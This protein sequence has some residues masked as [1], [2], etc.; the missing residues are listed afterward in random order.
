MVTVVKHDLEFILKQIKIAER[1]AAG[2]D[3]D[4]L[5]A[6]AGGFD[7]NSPASPQ[8][9]L[10]PYG[11]RTVD[12]SY[13]NLL[14]GRSEWGAADYEFNYLTEQSY[15]QGTGTFPYASNNDYGSSGDVVDSHPRLISNLIVDQTLDNPAAIIAAL[16][17]AGVTGTAQ[18]TALQNIRSVYQTLKDLSPNSQS[19]ATVKANLDT[20]LEQHGIEMDGVTIL[21]PN[22]S[23]DIGDSAPYNS[24][25]TLFG[26]F[27][28]HGLDLV[29]KGG[30]GTIY[31]PLS[32]DDPLYNPASPQ[33][34]F[35]VLT[36]ASTG[37]AARNTTTPWVDQNQT[38]GSHASKQVFMRQYVEGPDGKPMDS[39]YLLGHPDGMATWADV[40]E[41]ARTV[42]GIEL[43]DT[44]VGNIPLIAADEYGNFIEGQNGYPQLVVGFGGDGIFGTEDDVLV[45][46]DPE[47]PVSP[48]AVGAFRTG[49]AFIDDIAHNAVPGTTYYVNGQPVVVQP[50]ED[51]ETDDEGNPILVGNEIDTDSLGNKVAYDDELLDAHYVTGD[52]RGNENIGLTAIH[53]VFHGEHNRMVD[54]TKRVALEAAEDGD[55]TF[56]NEWLL[57]KVTEVPEDLEDLVWDGARL[58]QA[59]RFVTEMEYQHLVFEEFARKMQPDVDAFLFEPDPDI[60]PA[61]FAEFANVVYRFGHSMLNENVERQYA[62]GERGD[63]KLFEA[64]LNPVGYDNNGALTH[65]QAAGAIIRGMSGQLGNEIDEFVTNTLR[66]QL[67]GIPLDLASINIARGRDT[68]MPT[69]N[70]ARAQFQAMAGGDTQLKPYDNWIDFAVN[71]KNPASI[72]NFIAAYGTH[73]L[74]EAETTIDGKRA[75]A[76]AIVFGTDEQ[77]WDPIISSYRTIAAPSAEDRAAFLGASGDYASNLGGLNSVDLWVGGLAEKK[78]DFG[79]MLGS[80]FS[81]IFEMQ[82]ERLQ[83]ADRFYYLSRVQGLNLISELEGNS[84]AKMIQRN[85][86]IGD[87][88]TAIPGDIF[89][90]PDR[91]LY[92][93]HDKQMAMTGLDDPQHE[94]IFWEA[95]LGKMVQRGVDAQGRNYLRYDGVEHVVIQGTDD[96]DHII[97]GE[98]DD[99]VWG[100]DGNDR[101]EAGYGVDHI[102]GGKGDDI[103]TN[104]GTDIGQMDFL[105][106]E[107]GNDVIHGGSGLALI[108]GNQGNDFLIAGPDGKQVWGGIGDDFIMGGDGMDFLL[109]E[110]GDD[111]IEGGDRFDTLAGENSELMFNSTIKGNDVLNGQGGDT[112]YDAEA[113]DDIM[114]QGTGIQRS[115]GMA[116]FDWAIHKD[117]PNAANSDLGIPIFANQEAFILRD[118][119]DL[120]EGLSGWKHDDTL[121]GRVVPV[122][123]RVEATGTA[124]IPAPGMPLYAYS[125]ALLKENVSLIDGLDKIVAHLTAYTEVGRDGVPVQVLFETADASDI[126]LGGGGSDRIKGLAGNDIIDGD[127][128]LNVRILIK[129]GDQVYTADGMTRQVFRNI[130]MVNGALVAGAVA[131][132]GGKGLDTLMLEGTLN[133]GQLSIVREIVNGNKPGDIDT[134][135]YT[136]VRANYDFG[137]NTDA[138]LYVDHAPPASDDTDPLTDNI[139]GVNER[140]VLDGRDTV[141]NI[142]RLEFTDLTMNVI[143]GTEN[144]ETLNGD[145]A[146]TGGLIHDVLMGFEGDDILNGLTGDDVLIGGAGNDILRGGAGDD[147]YVFGLNDGEDRIEDTSGND[148]I[149]I[150]SDG[151][152]LSVLNFARANNGDIIVNVNGTQI[153]VVGHFGSNPSTAIETISFDGGDY[154]GYQLYLA[155]DEGDEVFRG[156]FALSTAVAANEDGV[157]TLRAEAGV[158]TILADLN[159]TQATT[160]LGDSADDMLFGN[161]GADILNGGAGAD[162]LVGGAG[163]DTYIVDD[164]GDTVVELEGGGNSDTVQASIDSYTLDANVE[165][166]IYTGTGDFT[167]AGNELNNNIT[168]GAGNDSLYGM[169]G[170]DGIAGGAGDDYLSGGAGNDTLSGGAGD[171]Y[172][173]GGDGND[174]LNGGDG[175]DIIRGGAGNDTINVGAGFNT[176]VYDT[177]DFGDDVVA[178]F[179]ANPN[180]GQ[181]RIDLRGSGITDANFDDRVTITSNGTDTLI[182]ITGGGTIRL[183]GVTGSG[184]NAIS[185]ADFILD[186]DRTIHGTANADVINGTAASDTILGHAG[187]DTINGLAGDDIIDGGAG[188]DDIFGGTGDDTI[189][190]RA[191][192]TGDGSAGWDVIDGGTEGI[193]GDTFDITGNSSSEIFRFY[194]FEDAQALFPEVTFRGAATEIVVTRTVVTDG[195]EGTP[196]IIAELAEI[197]EIVINGAPA[198]VEGVEGGDRYELIGDFAEQGEE[199][200]L[201][202]NTITINGSSGNDT[203]DISKLASAHRIVFRTKGGND[204]IIGKLRPQDVVL[205]PLNTTLDDYDMVHN[206]NGTTTLVS[207][208]NTITFFSPTGLPQFQVDDGSDGH[209]PPPAGEPV[210]D[211][212]TAPVDNDGDTNTPGNGGND[213]D[214]EDAEDEDDDD[215]EDDDLDDEEEEDDNEEGDD[216]GAAVGETPTGPGSS[217]T[218]VLTGTAGNDVLTGTNGRDVIMGGDGNDVILGG[219]GADILYGD[220]G[221]DHIFG[222]AGDDIIDGGAG[223]DTLVGGA[224][225]DYFIARKNDGDDIYFGDELDGGDGNDTLDLGAINANITAD[226]GTGHQG[227]GSVTSSQTGYDTLW[228]IENIITGSGNDTITA[229]KAIN[230]IDGG[231][232]DDTFRFLSAADADGDTILNFQPGDKIDLSIMDADW[233]ASGKQAFTL[234]S[235]AFTGNSGELLVT[236][237]NRDGADYTVVQGNSSGGLDADFKISIKGSHALT[238]SDFDL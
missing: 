83:D 6:E 93:D 57:V 70:E 131:Q 200:S 94:N 104:A 107:E 39:G 69:L 162:L 122:N 152:S 169:E 201:R 145:Q 27:F 219:Q 19:Y 202:L 163:N 46:G 157:L 174:T 13:N 123:T 23:P 87:T 31:I 198:G 182:S 18:A 66:N 237:E 44:D 232:G 223:N 74:I 186:G 52:G 199:T 88:G 102:H 71:L 84:L 179:D 213:H 141:R 175:D 129:V 203:V 238:T 48:T 149:K 189:Y 101:I 130:D 150:A 12:G 118:R 97:A 76:M 234:V 108:F 90:T 132:F 115:N 167:G 21:L 195:V 128:W 61:I 8:A 187:N 51:T 14:P 159:G 40:K 196:Q 206:L 197:E 86:D 20:L 110:A 98:G 34:N 81:F 227:R 180:G 24:M 96:D 147:L 148:R 56:L 177:L 38:Y 68:G 53:H 211:D 161:N 7:P 117:D 216:D 25:F 120:V 77:V 235:G 121:T 212:D 29:A 26:Q 58:F 63:M 153:R 214:D 89:S 143:N 154:K 65:D 225:N 205:L 221:S 137:V 218:N 55:L 178:S 72:V 193:A 17:H 64:F 155:D 67:L 136:D 144:G 54:E 139:E 30:N 183:T 49:H 173:D 75:A 80:T 45:E 236:H 190:W 170:D 112:D 127:K 60:N 95:L 3:L 82:M 59:A 184:A 78:M 208:E 228:G 16:E 165:R 103:I 91:V 109:G 171:D 168:G 172:L 135:V 124:A 207:E 106:G 151:E 41:Q 176:I 156:T 42:L 229:N 47:N 22:V 194:P 113:G 36:R 224:G 126:L 125:N 1:H 4:K 231:A 140:P 220:A 35:M 32:P 73:A 185:W 2:E 192:E 116:G 62:D 209:L 105:H 111:W 233:L 215:H 99:T 138:S 92:V 43:S 9:H 79:G 11:L 37:D 181:D 191:T 166:L 28:D 158:S 15:G 204:T 226:L 5:V 217:H 142:E 134:A 85:T 146:G 119:F 210:D 188:N 33:T 50:D 222:D 133:P 164:Y 160:L 230:V 100:G 10:L 114:F